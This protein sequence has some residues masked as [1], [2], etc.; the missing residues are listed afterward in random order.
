MP[1]SLLVIRK[2]IEA[3]TAGLY[4]L[5]QTCF[6]VPWSKE[7]L[8]KD[9]TGNPNSMY[10]VAELSGKIIGYAG[11]WNIMEECHINN[12]AVLPEFRRRKIGM[13]IIKTLIEVTERQGIKSHTL[14]VRESNRAAI[15]MYEKMGFQSVGKRPGYYEDNGEAAVIMWRIADPGKKGKES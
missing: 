11:V 8:I 13:T 14:E 4:N 10:F 12:V 15:S 7:S 9:I 2:G 5:E 6:T 1:K 3:D